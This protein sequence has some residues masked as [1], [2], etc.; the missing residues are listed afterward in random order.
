MVFNSN[1][2]YTEEQP[3]N[4]M[5]GADILRWISVIS[6][7]LRFSFRSFLSSLIPFAKNFRLKS[8][9]RGRGKDPDRTHP[10]ALKYWC[11]MHLK[12]LKMNKN[13]NT[14]LKSLLIDN[15]KRE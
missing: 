5:S 13:L 12:K 11:Q 9:G 7:S 2:C 6:F 14:Y 10:I 15:I 1:N 4:T 3:E 8:L